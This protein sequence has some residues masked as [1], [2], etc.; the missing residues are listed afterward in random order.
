MIHIAI[1]PAPY[2]GRNNVDI[3][4]GK[5][6]ILITAALILLIGF[7]LTVGYSM[8][9]QVERTGG[10]IIP[11]T[12]FNDGTKTLTARIKDKN[13]PLVNEFSAYIDKNSLSS[14]KGNDFS[15]LIYRL[16]SQ[17]YEV[18]FNDSL[19]GSVGNMDS[20]RSHTYNS[21]NGFTVDKDLVQESNKITI[22][23]Y[24]IYMTGLERDSVGICNTIDAMR[25]A[26]ALNLRTNGLSM[27]GIGAILFGILVSLLVYIRSDRKNKALIY[28]AAAVIFL[29]IYSLD[30]LNLPYLSTSY[31]FFK[32]IIIV[33]LYSC[34]FFF[35]LAFYEYYKKLYLIAA[36]SSMLIIVLIASIFT[37]T[38]ITFKYIYDITTFGIAASLLIWFLYSLLSKKHTEE[39]LVFVS[40]T[41]MLLV[42]AVSDSVLLL[43]SGGVVSTSI[44]NHVM[45][46]IFILVML[47]N[48]E[49]HRRNVRITRESSQRSHY[50]MQSI[51]DHL[52]GVFNKQYMLTSLEESIPPL[53]IAMLDLDNFKEINDNYGHQCGDFVLE[54][55]AAKMREEFRD[56]DFV[57]R[58]GGDEFM[59]ILV[60]CSERN[61]FDIMNRFRMH[62]EMETLEYDGNEIRITSSV[63]IVYTS[64]K[65]ESSKLVKKA[66][67][68]LY[69]AKHSGRNRVSI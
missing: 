35:G 43:I 52:T 1:S 19:I 2:L 48:F 23:S 56:T 3:M 13:E 18:Y 24:G 38:L 27:A 30:Y 36:S 51:T 46:F 16:N 34:I 22:R 5:E 57:G 29:G 20:G 59:I 7:F 60:G 6:Y 49:L 65:V 61:A 58:Y 21:A 68:A 9:N 17:A 42:I 62:L 53:S 45:V 12:A 50:Y 8:E 69:R 14:I 37:R 66:D 55:V 47:M 44:I 67:E 41:L 54:H 11:K 64:E 10:F 32:K 39:R 26:G 31:V 4:K 15:I 63:G 28:L 33:S 25:I 40:S